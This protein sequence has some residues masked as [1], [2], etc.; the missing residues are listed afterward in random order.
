MNKKPPFEFYPLATDT[1]PLAR[2]AEVPVHAGFPCP[3]DDAYMQQ[4]ID[5]NE[6]FIKHPATTYLVRVTGDSM[7]DE[8]VEEGDFLIVDRSMTPTEKHLS[9]CMF[10]GE[11]ALKRI[12]QSEGHVFLMAGNKRYKPIEVTNNE[13]FRVFGVVVWLMKKKA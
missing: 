4:P 11:F 1:K 3:V 13:D 7:I 6:A 8:G 2:L 10:G 9:V 12:V 5:M